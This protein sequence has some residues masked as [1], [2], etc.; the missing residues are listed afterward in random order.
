MTDQT[1]RPPRT[2]GTAQSVQSL[3][4]GLDVQGI[5][6]R[7][8][9]KPRDDFSPPKNQ[10]RLWGPLSFL[11]N[12]YRGFLTR[13]LSGRGG[14]LT[15]HLHSV[16]RSRVN[17]IILPLHHT[18]SWCAWEQLEEVCF[19]WIQG[20]KIRHTYFLVSHYDQFTAI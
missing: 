4:Y 7:F 12:R 8:P 9:E 5:V 16:L 6:A 15:T 17:G 2:A 14:M 1:S 11:F 20:P 10:D 3:G 19:V 13:R 18:P